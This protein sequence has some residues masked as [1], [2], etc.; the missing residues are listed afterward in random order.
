MADDEA[1]L[2][3]LLTNDRGDDPVA[4]PGPEG[5]VHC[6]TAAQ[7]DYVLEHFFSG[8]DTVVVLGLSAAVLGDAVVSEPGALGEAEHFPHCYGPIPRAAV[9][10]VTTRKRRAGGRW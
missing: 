5:Y 7:V 4:V 1:L 2:Y 10:S 3:L 8:C 9:C 6:C